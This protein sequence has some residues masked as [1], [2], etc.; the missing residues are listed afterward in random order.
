MWYIM[1]ALC[2][3]QGYAYHYCQCVIIGLYAVFTCGL[4]QVSITIIWCIHWYSNYV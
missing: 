2:G 1:V 4:W 3:T